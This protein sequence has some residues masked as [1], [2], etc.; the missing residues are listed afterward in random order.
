[1]T[2][3]LPVEIAEQ[4]SPEQY[5][6]LCIKVEKQYAQ[7]FGIVSVQDQGRRLRCIVELKDGTHH[8][9]NV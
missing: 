1:V 3:L 7:E 9:V 4:L 2:T 5:V 8:T 6:R